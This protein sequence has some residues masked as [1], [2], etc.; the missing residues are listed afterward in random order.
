MFASV[1]PLGGS[2]RELRPIILIYLN[3]ND[4]QPSNSLV[5]KTYLLHKTE[6]LA[7][8]SRGT[9][10]GHQ[11]S[12]P[13]PKENKLSAGAWAQQEQGH[14]GRKPHRILHTHHASHTHTHSLHILHSHMFTGHHTHTPHT[15]HISH[16]CT[17][18]TTHH[19]SCTDTS[20]TYHTTSQPHITDI[21]TH[22]THHTPHTHTHHTS[23]NCPSPDEAL[24]CFL[25]SLVIFSSVS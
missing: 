24:A 5:L 23:R 15:C 6:R 1:W 2:Q 20:R 21:T 7:H 19:I 22:S 8:T 3:S 25:A 14:D 13:L 12:Q 9:F 18:H 16:T 17:S 11:D 4:M 10:P